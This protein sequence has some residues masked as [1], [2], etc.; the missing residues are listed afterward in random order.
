ML[1]VCSS[2]PLQLG[3]CCTLHRAL[4][5]GTFNWTPHLNREL[6][7]VQSSFQAASLQ[8]VAEFPRL[9]ACRFQ[10]G[11]SV[12]VF[13]FLF[14]CLFPERTIITYPQYF[15]KLLSI[16][17]SIIHSINYYID[18]NWY[19]P[20]SLSCKHRWFSRL[21]LWNCNT[22]TTSQNERFTVGNKISLLV[23]NLWEVLLRGWSEKFP[24]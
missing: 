14:V 13:Q 19:K 11:A 23:N 6:C 8:T 17:H 7:F 22:K 18:L 10:F 2:V 12:L 16:N 15:G 21:N 5:L 4:V 20:H 9:H 1:L 24:T 3:Q